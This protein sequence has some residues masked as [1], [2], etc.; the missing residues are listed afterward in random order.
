MINSSARVFNISI[1]KELTDNFHQ[2]QVKLFLSMFNQFNPKE[3]IDAFSKSHCEKAQ[4]S[5]TRSLFSQVN[6]YEQPGNHIL[7]HNTSLSLIRYFAQL[8]I[9]KSL[10]WLLSHLY[11]NNKILY[12]KALQAVACIGDVNAIE[13]M[14]ETQRKKP[15]ES[16]NM[17][18]LK[19][20]AFIF[21]IRK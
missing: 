17:I 18:T 10:P 7:S 9:Q 11:S 2:D 3:M 8:K 13:L 1:F 19:K 14:K 15:R 12:Q 6:N 4:D 20:V 5:I 21:M 16:L